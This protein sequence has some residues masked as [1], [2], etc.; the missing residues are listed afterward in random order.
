MKK[1]DYLDGKPFS[2]ND[3]ENVVYKRVKTDSG[4][5]LERKE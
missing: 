5:N 4:V 3:S 1:Q 2:C